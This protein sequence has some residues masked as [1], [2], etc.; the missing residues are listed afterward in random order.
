MMPLNYILWKCTGQYE[1]TKIKGKAQSLN[2]N[3]DIKL[4]SKNEK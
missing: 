2:V 3:G 1:R 4:L